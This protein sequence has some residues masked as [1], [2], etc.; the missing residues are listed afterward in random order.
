MNNFYNEPPYAKMLR[1]LVPDNGHITD[2]VR[3]NYVKTLC[4]CMIGNGY[5]VSN[6]A[7]PIYEELF[8]KFTDN[9]IKEFI[10]LFTDGDI[11]SRIQF[12]D[13]KEKYRELLTTLKIK[14]HR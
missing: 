1:K 10:T 13:C 6:M 8:N 9:E 7:Y 4:L 3:F 5:G 2:S 11:N 12:S 14:N